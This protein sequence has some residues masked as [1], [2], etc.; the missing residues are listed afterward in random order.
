MIQK[1]NKYYK[2]LFTSDKRYYILMGGRSAGRSTTASQFALANLMGERYFRCAIMRFVY[3][4][5]RN[6]IFQDIKDRADE[7]SVD[8]KI[9]IKEHVLTFNYRGNKI[10]GIGFRKSSSDQK[11]KLK[12]LA[13]Y[14][15]VIIEE[16]DE[17]SED[18]FLQLDD[19]LRT[20]KSDIKIILLLNPP[21]KNHWI[22][23]RWFNLHD[24]VDGFFKASLKD[25][26][27]KDTVFI[28][29]TYKQNIQNVNASSIANFE[30]Y[31]IIRPDHYYNMIKGYIS[32]GLRGRIFKNWIA[33]PDDEFDALEYP[34][35]YGLDFGFT[36]DPTALIEI[37]KHN[38]KVWVRELIYETGLTNPLIAQRFTTLGLKKD[39]P[40]YA[41]NA[42]PKSI[43]ELVDFGWDV[44]AAIKGPGS[45][46]A[47]I[48]MLLSKIVHYTESSSNIELETQ[49]YI[50]AL[51][52]NKEPTNN[53]ID[54]FNHCMDGIRYG[55][56][57]DSYE[58]FIGFV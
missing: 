36:N 18:D 51:D 21:D 56:Y 11:S 24:I 5:I 44:V 15:C 1:I 32:D 43:Q 42:E 26:Y 45:V 41:D 23:K 53:P 35:F 25:S 30:R 28:S 8:D 52:K 58:S 50:W 37:K 55:V 54:A 12:S 2:E 14:N 29:T 31:K 39:V 6:S 9:E 34:S 40:I 49:K 38:E 46:N 10:N 19:S 13:N 20:L 22:V 47:G 17:V 57:T 27:K 16:A 33:I 48:D 4:D 7:Q 3:G